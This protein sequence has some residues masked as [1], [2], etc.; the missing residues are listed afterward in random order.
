MMFSSRWIPR[1]ALL[2]Q[3]VWQIP[4]ETEPPLC[5]M[6]SDT[7]AT[8]GIIATRTLGFFAS[9]RPS[10]QTERAFEKLK[11][12]RQLLED[13]CM[14]MDQEDK[15]TIIEK[16]N[17]AR[18]IEQ[19]S[20]GGFISRFQ[21]SRGFLNAA[22]D[23]H[24]FAKRVSERAQ[25]DELA[26]KLGFGGERAPGPSD[27]ALFVRYL[28]YK[29]AFKVTCSSLEATT[30][31]A[32]ESRRG[33]S[34]ADLLSEA[35]SNIHKRIPE[36]R[37]ATR[38]LVD[39]FCRFEPGQS[40]GDKAHNKKVVGIELEDLHFVHYTR[41]RHPYH[42][43]LIQSTI[44]A[45]WFQGGAD[46]KTINYYR[47]SMS[48]PVTALAFAVIHCC[49]EDWSTGTR[50]SSRWDDPHFEKV[51][52]S[53]LT[54]LIDYR[55]D[56]LVRGDRQFDELQQE[57]FNQSTLAKE[58]APSSTTLAATPPIIGHVC[59]S[60]HFPIPEINVSEMS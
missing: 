40:D 57:L 46:E 50:D 23:A 56:E 43:P 15:L 42:H 6:A 19:F 32:G 36:M 16:M 18:E 4:G 5:T 39:R 7:N 37:L 17:H 45:I 1:I 49:L 29:G 55:R 47:L 31:T 59:L 25:D 44:N 8:V 60:V 33:T 14:F 30:Q 28:L 22:R 13:N 21:Q 38:P 3:I 51:Y 52:T 58:S 54:S 11:K 2:W 35:L 12:T 53:L 9:Q 48:T 26:H 27:S 41:Q 20:H 10:A 24:Q 34:V